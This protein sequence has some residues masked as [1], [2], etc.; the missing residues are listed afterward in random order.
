MLS[1]QI[2]KL[3]LITED[4][5][6]HNLT[7]SF[8]AKFLYLDGTGM[9]PITRLKRPMPHENGVDD[10]GFRLEPRRMTL[11]MYVEAQQADEAAAGALYDYITYLFQPTDSPLILQIT[12]FDDEVRRIE[13]YLDGQIDYPQ[14]SRIGGSTKVLIPLYAPDPSFY[15]PT[16]RVFNQDLNGISG[17]ILFLVVPQEATWED[18]P[19]M[20][21][22]GPLTTW[23]LDSSTINFRLTSA[24]AV[25]SGET[26]IFD[27]RQD[28]KKVY[29]QSD[30]ANRLSYVSPYVL[31]AFAKFKIYDR[32]NL[33]NYSVLAGSGR[34]FAIVVTLTASGSGP[35]SYLTYRWY[36]RFLSL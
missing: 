5:I 27:F 12:R 9:P 10:R 19:V 23:S 4:G 21:L 14:S 36:D 33:E 16:Q 1:K 28:Q 2:K 7:G 25:P 20:E 11:A 13:C 8:P 30:N 18:W 34:T 22:T 29:R 31:E 17:V 26:F 35:G 6:T 24:A 32:K 15:D 3:E